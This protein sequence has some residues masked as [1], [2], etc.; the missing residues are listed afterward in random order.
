M[1]TSEHFS[2][3]VQVQFFHIVLCLVGLQCLQSFLLV[4]EITL[5]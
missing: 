2:I 3:T 4:S 1:S 5:F